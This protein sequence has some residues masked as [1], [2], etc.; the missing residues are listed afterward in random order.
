APPRLL[1]QENELANVR[2]L[3]VLLS[4]L[5][6]ALGLIYLAVIP[7]WG[8]PDEPR[9]FE[10]VAL[11]SLKGRTVGYGDITPSVMNDIIRSMDSVNYWKW[12]V[13]AWTRTTPGELPNDF[14]AI[15]GEGAHQLHQP[16]LAYLLYLLPYRLF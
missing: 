5:T 3:P 13:S 12:G 2:A 1:V 14:T 11:L 4:I 16:P 10:Y 7:P 9:H 6:L 8:G 15:Y